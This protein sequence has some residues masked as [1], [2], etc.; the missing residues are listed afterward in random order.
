MTEER[1]IKMSSDIADVIKAACSDGVT[2]AEVAA[3][4]CGMLDLAFG[5]LPPSEQ[6]GAIVGALDG[7]L[8]CAIARGV[9]LPG[10]LLWTPDD[11]DERPAALN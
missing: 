3:V 5:D 10:D 11:Y 1:A 8:V 4:L 7:F 6:A 2:P 9:E